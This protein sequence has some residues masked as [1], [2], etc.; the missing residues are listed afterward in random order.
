MLRYL[1]VKPTYR[2]VVKAAVLSDN[3][4]GTLRPYGWRNSGLGGWGEMF[5]IDEKSICKC[6]ILF[7]ATVVLRG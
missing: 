2:I 3:F 4:Y 1:L 5:V 7:N 6:S